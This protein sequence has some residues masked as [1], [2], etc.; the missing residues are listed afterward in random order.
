MERNA[1]LKRKYNISQDDYDKLHEA[2]GGR[3]AI[4]GKKKRLVVDHDHDTGE[5]RGLLCGNC[6]TGIGMLGDTP[7]DLKNALEY[8]EKNDS[9]KIR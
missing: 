1:R 3:C 2:Q 4:C 7:G 8:L 5:V 9:T 6:N